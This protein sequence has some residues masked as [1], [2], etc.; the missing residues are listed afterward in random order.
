MTFRLAA[1]DVR[2]LSHL[3]AA[4]LSDN[5]DARKQAEASLAD[6][7]SRPGYCAALLAVLQHPE[8]EVSTKW[9]AVVQL[10]NACSSRWMQRS[11]PGESS[12][13]SDAEKQH[14]RDHILQLV[15][16]PDTKLA[17]HVAVIISRIARHD[18]PGRWP[19]LFTQLAAPLQQPGSASELVLK[20]TWLTLHHVIKELAAK[21]LPA[22]KRRLQELAAQLLPSVWHAWQAGAQAFAAAVQPAAA[23]GSDID[24]SQASRAE[25]WM[26]ECKVLRRLIM[27]GVPRCAP[28]LSTLTS[29]W[30]WTRRL[31]NGIAQWL[32]RTVSSAHTVAMHV[33]KA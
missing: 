3:L 29:C 6:L 26:L 28:S 31:A 24:S 14:I 21:R 9:Q 11:R 32:R 23:A 20:R 16:L 27:N 1:E 12:A 8:V 19:A 17:V 33:P 22:D 25:Q 10:K 2:Q 13:L 4:A 30:F 18:F 7:S 15:G 5:G